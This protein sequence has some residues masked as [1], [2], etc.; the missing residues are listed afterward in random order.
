MRQVQA[1]RFKQA[2]PRLKIG[3]GI[4]DK[5]DAPKAHFTFI[6]GTE[7]CVSFWI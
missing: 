1:T 7:V 3:I 4:H 2:N 6:D 5:T